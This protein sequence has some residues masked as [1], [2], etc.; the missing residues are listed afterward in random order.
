MYEFFLKETRSLGEVNKR[1]FHGLKPIWNLIVEN[2]DKTQAWAAYSAIPALSLKPLGIKTLVVGGWFDSEDLAGALKT[3]QV[4]SSL[5]PS[6][7]T[8]VMGPWAH[9]Y[10]FPFEDGMDP[11]GQIFGGHNFSR[12]T[13]DD[14]RWLQAQWFA[15]N[16]KGGYSRIRDR[17]LSPFNLSA[18][19]SGAL[20]F[21]T[22]S[23]YWNVL[24]N[25]PPVAAATETIS[26]FLG[27]DLKL[28]RTPV[29]DADRGFDEYLSDPD[30]P[31][32]YVARPIGEFYNS[33]RAGASWR[34]ADQRFSAD[35]VDVL[36]YE[37]EPL[38][39]NLTL[40]GRVNATVSWTF[41]LH[42]RARPVFFL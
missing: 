22:G 40:A 18:P 25:W 3:Y 5:D 39:S 4:Y 29:A 26:L 31:V 42:R 41:R 13:G 32:P 30:K 34:V 37:T 14:F 20:L 11:S 35:R 21:S 1:Y 7:T 28:L 8:L 17:R 6:N 9:G 19:A 15:E 24:E 10:W 2:P 27:S 23:N 12:P 38:T 16:L 33:T 36:V